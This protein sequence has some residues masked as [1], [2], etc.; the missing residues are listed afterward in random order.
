MWAMNPTLDVLVAESHSG[1]AA[2]A[3]AI[4]R[5]AG[6]RTHRCYDPESQGFPCRGLLE[7]DG[8]PIDHGIDVVLLARRRILPTPASLENGVICAIRAGIPVAEHGTEVLDPFAP[9]VSARVEDT[10]DVVDACE[11]AVVEG[12]EPL[13][14]HILDSVEKVLTAA[15]VESGTLG[16]TIERRGSRLIVRLS[17]PAIAERLRQAAAVEAVA[18]VQRAGVDTDP[19][20]VSYTAKA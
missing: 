4:L 16:C 14:R 11:Y 15:G 7:P 6:H 1:T 8:C 19:L 2:E 13:R 20:D 3:E 9:W 10:A 18:A 12:L 17:G 5:N